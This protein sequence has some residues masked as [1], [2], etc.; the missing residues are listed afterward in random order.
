MERE[1]STAVKEL[2]TTLREHFNQKASQMNIEHLR[3]IKELK[4]KYENEIN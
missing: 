2:E 1:R 3:E 4:F